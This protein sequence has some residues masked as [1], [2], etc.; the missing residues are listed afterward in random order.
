M[1]KLEFLFALMAT[2]LSMAM[3]TPTED[4]AVPVKRAEAGFTVGTV[5]IYNNTY[6][7]YWPDYEAEDTISLINGQCYLTPGDSAQVTGQSCNVYFYPNS[8][9]TGNGTLFT[10]S[11]WCIQIYELYSVKAVCTSP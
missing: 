8:K 3:S 9:C 6:C 4:I 7:G 5:K 2:L 1:F 10:P 11:S